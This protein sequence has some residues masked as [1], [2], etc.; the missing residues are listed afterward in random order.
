MRILYLGSIVF[1]MSG[2]FATD[3]RSIKKEDRPILPVITLH[4]EDT[5]L[6][7]NYVATVQAVRNVEIRA[8]I[9]GSL[10]KILV[11]EGRFVRKGQPMFELNK[12]V[13]AVDL[14]RAKANLENMKAEAQ[15][16]ALEVKRVKLL[17]DKNVISKSELE[18]AEA[19][20]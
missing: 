7:T 19:R 12:Q 14:E 6:N 13:F 20:V 2:C 4:A 8:K 15:M 18:L 16:A 9:G 17:V 1:L 5:I 11:D 3:S 10:E